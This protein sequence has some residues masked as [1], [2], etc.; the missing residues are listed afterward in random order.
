[1]NDRI[2]GFAVIASIVSG[3]VYWVI[4]FWTYLVK[5]LWEGLI[6]FDAFLMLVPILVFSIGGG[7]LLCVPSYLCLNKF[8][9]DKTA[10]ILPIA[11]LIAICIVNTVLAKW[12]GGY[13]TYLK[14]GVSGLTG[15]LVF[16]YLLRNI[17]LEDRY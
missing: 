6:P 2:I 1:M 17:N 12:Y 4:E 16:C 15:G 11:A 9:I 5:I 3:L 7:I 8:G 14:A 10:I 13:E